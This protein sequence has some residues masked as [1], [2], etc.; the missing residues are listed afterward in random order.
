[1]KL[2]KLDMSKNKRKA[3]VNKI[4]G[5][6]KEG[7]NG[8]YWYSV[9]MLTIIEDNTLLRKC[10]SNKELWIELILVDDDEQRKQVEEVMRGELD[11]WSPDSTAGSIHQ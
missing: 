3:T 6:I 8:E 1:M 5:T 11:N 10:L 2:E 4:L 7:D 9:M